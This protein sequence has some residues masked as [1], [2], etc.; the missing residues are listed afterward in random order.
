MPTAI[1]DLVYDFLAEKIAAVNAAEAGFD[2]DDEHSPLF[3]A[4]LQD[5]PFAEVEEK[6]SNTH[7]IIVDD[8]ESD[9]APNAGQTAVEEFDGNVT[10]IVYW[11]ADGNDRSERKAARSKAIGLAIAVAKLFWD[12]NG[13]TMNNRVND[14]RALRLIRGWANWKSGPYAIMN[15][16]LLINDTGQSG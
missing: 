14:A 8:G 2:E 4:Q 7:G 11:S 6:A 10:L 13:C 3:E 5:T 16:P 15:L 9:L 12:D 1:E